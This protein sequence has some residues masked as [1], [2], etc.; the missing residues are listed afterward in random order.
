MKTLCPL[1]VSKTSELEISEGVYLVCMVYILVVI[2]LVACFRCSVCFCACE[3]LA[4]SKK[5]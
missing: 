4:V 2:V 1:R 3:F 5:K